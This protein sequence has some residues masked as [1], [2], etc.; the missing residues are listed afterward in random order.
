MGESLIDDSCLCNEGGCG[1][2]AGLVKPGKVPPVVTGE[3]LEV[4]A[5]FP[6]PGEDPVSGCLFP[7]SLLFVFPAKVRER[8]LIIVSPSGVMIFLGHRLSF[9]CLISPFL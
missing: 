3:Q 9:V 6:V 8:F 7:V 5:V 4:G 2:T 1:T